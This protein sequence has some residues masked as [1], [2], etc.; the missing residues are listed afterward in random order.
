[1]VWNRNQESFFPHMITSPVNP[2]PLHVT[3]ITQ[4]STDI[5]ICSCSFYSIPLDYLSILE[6][7]PHCPNYWRFINL[8]FGRNHFFFLRKRKTNLSLFT[9]LSHPYLTAN[10]L[11]A[12]TAE[13]FLAEYLEWFS[14][15]TALQVSLRE[16]WPN[17]GKQG[18]DSDSPFM[19][20]VILMTGLISQ[21]CSEN[22]KHYM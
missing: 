16:Q 1:M 21:G 8:K 2:A 18:E 5:W 7:K 11:V 15:I 12:A 9:C 3:F 6:P 20:P 10:G 22:W 4:V 19:R 17:M 14:Y 13:W